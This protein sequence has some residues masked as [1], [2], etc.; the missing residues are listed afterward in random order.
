M[1]NIHRNN[2]NPVEIN[3]LLMWPLNSMHQYY[4]DH[5]GVFSNTFISKRKIGICLNKLTASL[6]FS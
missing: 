4:M 1:A 5:I 2:I 3:I 6:K